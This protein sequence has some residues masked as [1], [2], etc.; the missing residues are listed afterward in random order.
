LV[1]TIYHV[2]HKARVQK[3]RSYP[4]LSRL[5]AAPRGSLLVGTQNFASNPFYLRI[6]KRKN[7]AILGPRVVNPFTRQQET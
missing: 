2:D 4:F 3:S 5:I 7:K 1:T 6:K